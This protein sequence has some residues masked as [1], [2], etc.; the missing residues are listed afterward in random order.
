VTVTLRPLFS[1]YGGKWRAAPR[2]PAPRYDTII[3]PFA[4]SAGYA[5]RY[6][7]RNVVLVEKNAKVAATWRY[8]LRATEA[9]AT[10][11]DLNVCEE[12][13]YLIGFSVNAATTSPSKSLSKWATTYPTAQFWGE[14]R[15]VLL[16]KSV[17]RIRHWTL[18]EGDYADAP[19]V[20][21]TWFID[22]PYI[23]AGKHYP[24]QPDD[25]EALAVWCR[26]RRGQV[27]VC[28][29]V[30]ATW[31]PFRPFLKIKANQSR[32]GGKTSHEALWTND[33][34]ERPNVL[35]PTPENEP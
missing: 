3:E 29:N 17:S 32:Y 19:D 22:P 28:E 12:A 20:E 26:S 24:T 23:G 16:S 8:L 1:Y 9:G 35:F 15:R 2:Y 25:F 31:L 7:E 30:G 34:S 10:V 11:D 6:P 13:R 14:K 21:A 5:L 27:M 18:I 33:G 4:G